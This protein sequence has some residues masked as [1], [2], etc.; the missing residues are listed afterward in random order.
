MTQFHSYRPEEGHRLAHEPTNSIIAPRPIGWIS[1]VSA[2]GVAN[3]APYSLF[4]LFSYRPPIIGFSSGAEKDSVVNA[5]A[6]GEF[7]W[8]LVGRDLTD[9]MIL[10]SDEVGPEV[11]EFEM[12]GLEKLAS[13]DVAPPRV[14]ASA[15]QFECKVTQIMQLNDIEGKPTDYRMVFGQVVHVHINSACIVENVYQ[16]THPVP[17]LRGGG[18]ADYYEIRAEALFQQRRR[19]TYK[20]VH[21]PR[22]HPSK[23]L[24]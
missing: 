4:N 20:A 21:R 15:V 22:E 10:T 12:V 9:V 8:N 11:D 1:T 2:D 19:G 5:R 13:I 23:G 14:A 24:P 18:P 16:T 17:V 7:V 3:I 6:T